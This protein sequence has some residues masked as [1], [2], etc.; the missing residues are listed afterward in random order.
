MDEKKNNC[1]Y[2][3]ADIL[4]YINQKQKGVKAYVH[5]ARHHILFIAQT[6]EQLAFVYLST[7]FFCILYFICF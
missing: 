1:A 5:R 3:L 2:M 4:Y 6:I 7:V